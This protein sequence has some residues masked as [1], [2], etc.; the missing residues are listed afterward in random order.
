VVTELASWPTTRL[1]APVPAR[2]NGTATAQLT[3]TPARFASTY[4]RCWNVRSRYALRTAVM[5][6]TRIVRVKTRIT[7]AAA[8]TPE[9]LANGG[10]ANQ[11]A[12]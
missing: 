7:G 6:S 9:M 1:I 4:R 12:T 3:P 10:A 5:P 11:N 8:G 2:P